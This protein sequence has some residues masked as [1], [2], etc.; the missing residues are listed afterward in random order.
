MKNTPLAAIVT[1]GELLAGKRLDAP[2]S[3]QTS[4]TYKRA[5]KGPAVARIDTATDP[6][7]I[8]LILAGATFA[9]GGTSC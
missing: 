9:R 8:S 2:P 1:V 6:Q 4:V 5:P 3:R 7:F